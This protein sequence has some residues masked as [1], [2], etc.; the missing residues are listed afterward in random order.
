[1]ELREDRDFPVDVGDVSSRI[2]VV[3]VRIGIEIKTHLAERFER[4]FFFLLAEEDVSRAADEFASREMGVAV[5]DCPDDRIESRFYLSAGPNR[6]GIRSEKRV[7]FV[8]NAGRIGFLGDF[9]K[10]DRQIQSEEIYKDR[11]DFKN[12]GQRGFRSLDDVAGKGRVRVVGNGKSVHIG[13]LSYVHCICDT[14]AL[15]F[16]NIICARWTPS[17]KYGTIRAYS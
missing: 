15:R 6:L 17:R 9:L 2:L 12:L 3:F 1:M 16:V 5:R 8:Q 10:P 4:A 13:K 7:Q 14:Q 11:V